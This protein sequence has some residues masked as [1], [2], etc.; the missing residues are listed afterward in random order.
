ML[1][2]ESKG[3]ARHYKHGHLN[4][5]SRKLPL[6]TPQ[7]TTSLFPADHSRKGS[8]K[9]GDGGMQNEVRGRVEKVVACQSS[10]GESY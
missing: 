9:G 7:E 8:N 2:I 5:Y 1:I 3:E 6:H 10:L 4:S